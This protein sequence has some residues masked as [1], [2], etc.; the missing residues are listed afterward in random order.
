MEASGEDSFPL[1][2][3]WRRGAV[4]AELLAAGVL[5]MGCATG[6][7]SPAPAPSSA[8][9]SSAPAALS[10]ASA[11]PAPAGGT[12]EPVTAADLGASWRSGCPVEPERLRRVNV[13]HIGFDGQTH[14]GEL[15]VHADLVPEVIAIFEQLYRM[16]Y[17]VEKIRTVDHYSDADDELSM[18]DNNTS[19]FNCRR[20][21]GTDEW[22]QHAYGRAIDLNPLVNPC[23]YASGYFEPRNAAPYLDRGRTDP[24][25]L[26]S[27]D[28][29][30]RVFT[31]RGWRWGGE[32]TAPLDYQH[33]ERP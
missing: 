11:P 30:V 16:G 26:H 27:G 19:A 29:A 6:R 5:L 28:P 33:F 1:T 20:I 9:T 2:P 23:L 8:A 3:L 14:R 21:P 22:S 10:S 32:W 4:L 17:P 15:I 12:V 31:D 7:P 13:D 18:E 24:G 25:L